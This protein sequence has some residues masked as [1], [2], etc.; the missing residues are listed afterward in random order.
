MRFTVDLDGPGGEE[1]CQIFCQIG[2]VIGH[3]LGESRNVQFK[4]IFQYF[5]QEIYIVVAGMAR[6]IGNQRDGQSVTDV[7]V[8][9]TL[10]RSIQPN[11]KMTCGESK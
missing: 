8:G 4:F 6:I 11:N 3:R 1:T 9:S 10:F 7:D 2:G 5:L